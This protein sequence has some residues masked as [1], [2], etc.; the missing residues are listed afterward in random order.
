[1][2]GTLPTL[3]IDEVGTIDMNN[4]VLKLMGGGWEDIIT[5]SCLIVLCL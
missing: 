2:H 5:N 4:D 1:M 3:N